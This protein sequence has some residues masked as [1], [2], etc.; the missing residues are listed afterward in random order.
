[1]TRSP[2]PAR[3]GVALG[4]SG[5]PYTGSASDELQ[6]RRG[7]IERLLGATG[8]RTTSR[9]IPDDGSR[10]LGRRSRT[11]ACPATVSAASAAGVAQRAELLEAIGRDL[12]GERRLLTSG[13]VPAAML[14]GDPQF[15]RVCDGI[16]A[17]GPRPSSV[18]PSIWHGPAGSWC[19]LSTHQAPSRAAYALENRRVMTRVFPAVIA[20]RRGPSLPMF[21]R[22]AHAATRGAVASTI[23]P[24]WRSTPV[25]RSETAFEH[26]RLRRCSGCRWC[27]AR[28]RGR[29]AATCGCGPSTTSPPST[30]SCACDAS[31]AIPWSFARI[32]RSVSPGSWTPVAVALSRSSTAWG[33]ASSGPGLAGYLP[34]L[35]RHVLG[36]DLLLESRRRGGAAIP[37]GCGASSVAS[38]ELIVRPLSRSSAHRS[39]PG[40]STPAGIERLR[41]RIEHQP[42][43]GSARSGSSRRA[44]RAHRRGLEPRPTVLRSFAVAGINGYVVMAGGLACAVAV[45]RSFPSLGAPARSPRTP[46]SS[47]TRPDLEE[48]WLAKPL[49]GAG[50][51]VRRWRVP[52]PTSGSDATPARVE[53]TARLLRVVIDRRDD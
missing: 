10:D 35:C 36:E 2:C 38:V 15:N 1:M 31:S 18:S 21:V 9:V 49:P 45:I 13:I 48:F 44:P 27:R 30:W 8:S 41:R 14:L 7:E 50:C 12:Y 51:R 52:P 6:R 20:D 11:A 3:R 46:G 53:A 22:S 34:A 33:P 25:A 47:P 29:V 40:G 37:D 43:S 24:S 42:G 23:P 39:T 32:R 17:P 4:R 16:V 26:D 19:A 5:S 28:P